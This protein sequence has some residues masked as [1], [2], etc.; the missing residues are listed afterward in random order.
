MKRECFLNVIITKVYSLS[1]I[2]Y[3][4]YGVENITGQVYEQ[5][6]KG[7]NVTQVVV[8]GSAEGF[9][10][11]QHGC[12]ICL[13][14][15]I[16]FVQTIGSHYPEALDELIIIN[17]TPLIKVVLVALKPI[18]SKTNREAIKIFGMNKNEWM[19]YLD[20]KVSREERR[21][22]YGGTKPPVEY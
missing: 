11:I 12:P 2:R 19:E 3:L 10:L 16:Q 7:M 20:K 5:Q 14:I 18:L 9:N 1:L 21:Q 13:P 22:H 6:Q 8:L 4:I 17:G 15:W